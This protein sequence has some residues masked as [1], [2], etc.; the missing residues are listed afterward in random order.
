MSPRS[1]SGLASTAAP[2]T[3]FPNTR[4]TDRRYRGV[5]R[6]KLYT[7]VFGDPKVARNQPVRTS[8]LKG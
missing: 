8:A 7:V 3:T 5:G 1:L 4:A 2:L 6:E